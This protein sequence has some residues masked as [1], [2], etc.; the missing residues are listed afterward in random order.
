M[1]SMAQTVAKLLSLLLLLFLPGRL[2]VAAVE[3]AAPLFQPKSESGIPND[4]VQQSCRKVTPDV[5][6]RM[7]ATLHAEIVAHAFKSNLT[8]TS[9][10]EMS[11]VI[12]VCWRSGGVIRSDCSGLSSPMP[13]VLPSTRY[14]MASV[15]A[16]DAT[17]CS[18]TRYHAR[19][20]AQRPLWSCRVT[21]VWLSMPSPLVL[22]AVRAMRKLSVSIPALKFLSASVV[23]ERPTSPTR[24]MPST[25]PRWMGWI[26]R[27]E[28]C[29]PRLLF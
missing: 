20:K 19:M 23:E 3:S 8:Q 9:D 4:T 21:H 14:T 26:K 25:L 27:L 16:S 6:S 15:N 13:K 11:A 17:R 29:R 5:S 2:V 12:C 22:V 1:L 28:L 7:K 10:T 24:G 18:G